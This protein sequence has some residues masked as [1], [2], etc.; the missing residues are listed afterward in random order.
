MRYIERS[1][2]PCWSAYIC[3]KRTADCSQKRESMQDPP[4]NWAIQHDMLTARFGAGEPD[5]ALCNSM[6]PFLPSLPH[7]SPSRCCSPCNFHSLRY[8]AACAAHAVHWNNCFCLTAIY[9]QSRKLLLDISCQTAPASATRTECFVFLAALYQ[10]T[11]VL[12]HVT[13]GTD[14]GLTDGFSMLVLPM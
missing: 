1:V 12:V 5:G 3:M 9:V 10:P 14:A 6:A 2:T 7:N 8:T 13:S 4:S 11:H